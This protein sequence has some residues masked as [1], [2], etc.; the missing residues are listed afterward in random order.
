MDFVVEKKHRSL[1]ISLRAESIKHF[2]DTENIGMFI[3]GFPVEMAIKVATA[4][5]EA[6]QD[7]GWFVLSLEEMLLLS[8]DECVTL[9]Q[10]RIKE[11]IENAQ[12]Y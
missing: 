1:W 8:V 7:C 4:E 9:S 6:S 2:H 11:R 3:N 12:R 10:K 5:Y